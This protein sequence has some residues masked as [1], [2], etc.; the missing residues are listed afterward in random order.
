MIARALVA[1]AAAA[2]LCPNADAAP[3]TPQGRVSVAQLMEAIDLSPRDAA[4]RELLVAYL[5]GMTETAVALNGVAKAQTGKALFCGQG[6]ASVGG[7]EVAA[8]LR[9]AAPDKRSWERTEAAPILVRRLLQQR[10]C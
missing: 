7:A 9:Q 2:V 4:A 8:W 6:Q 10:P 5:S 3:R 1:L